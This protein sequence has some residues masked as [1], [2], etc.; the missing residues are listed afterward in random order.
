MKNRCTYVKKSENCKTDF[1][2]FGK[3]ESDLSKIWIFE[4]S[5]QM[6]GAI[7]FNLFLK[8]LKIMAT[9]LASALK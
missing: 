4:K 7:E 8:S 2:N 6:N 1:Q 3:M 9:S 5:K